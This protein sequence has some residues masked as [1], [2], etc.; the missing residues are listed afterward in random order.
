MIKHDDYINIFSII[1]VPMDFNL[2]LLI[3]MTNL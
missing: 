3:S 2:F 1:E